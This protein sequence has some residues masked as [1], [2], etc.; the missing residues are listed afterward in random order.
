MVGRVQFSVKTAGEKKEYMAP[1]IPAMKE[2]GPAIDG[3]AS[4]Q[5]HG[6]EMTDEPWKSPNAPMGS[7]AMAKAIEDAVAKGIAEGLKKAAPVEKV[8]VTKDAEKV[9]KPESKQVM[10]EEQRK[11]RKSEGYRFGESYQDIV[12]GGAR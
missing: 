9:E 10:T 1:A 11:V 7:K 5:E 6:G 4:S 8:A 2:K 3:E 12:F